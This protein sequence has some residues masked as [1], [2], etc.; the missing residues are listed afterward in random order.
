[1]HAISS[2]GRKFNKVSHLTQ[3]VRFHIVDLALLYWYHLNFPGQ[4][5]PELQLTG[6]VYSWYVR[7]L[8]SQQY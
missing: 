8:R 1:M 6:L 4:H 7:E 2:S 5:S 3:S